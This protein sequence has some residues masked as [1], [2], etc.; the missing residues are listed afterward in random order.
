MEHITLSDGP[1][2]IFEGKKY[3]DCSSYDFL[4]LSQHPEVKKGAIKYTLKYGVGV[5]SSPLSST[6][7]IELEY[8]FAQ[9][10]G[11][12]IA[13]F[14]PSIEEAYRL[15]HGYAIKT[16]DHPEFYLSSKETH[17]LICYQDFT[18][19]LKGHKGFGLAAHQE[20]LFFILGTF[21]QAA[22]CSGAY[23]AGPKSVLKQLKA[24]QGLGFP[25]LGAID[26]IL[27]LI[28]EMID[29]RKILEKHTLWLHKQFKTD[30]VQESFFP[31]IV[32]KCRSLT[33]AEMLRQV[34]FHH[35]IFISPQQ[36]LSLLILL[37]ALHTPDDLDQ[38]GNCLKKLSA[39]RLDLD[40]QSLTPI[41]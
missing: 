22:G 36:D 1:Y 27:N 34:F 23:L 29:E 33:E 14:V 16:V 25:I 26:T 35:Q 11:T 7:Q 5:P 19:G 6:P 4:G 24:S 10:L 12:E 30:D 38:L 31:K 28:P 37:T 20:S 32:I 3:L 17:D 18:L 2:V 39:T 9:L 40:I 41:P 8:K 13:L 15:I 21:S